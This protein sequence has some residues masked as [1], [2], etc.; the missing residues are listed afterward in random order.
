ML[1]IWLALAITFEVGWAVAMKISNGFT[2]P[3]PTAATIIMYLLSVVFLAQVTKRM[4]VGVAYA[5][6]AGAGA[7]LIAIAGITYF[8]EPVSAAKI[9]SILLIITGIV[10]LQITGNAHVS[11]PVNAPS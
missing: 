7:A 8:R 5:I 6:W 10:G 1:Y 4:D 11:T 3:I 9:I 2:R